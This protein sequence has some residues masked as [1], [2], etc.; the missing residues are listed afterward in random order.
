M[1][2]VSDQAT[3]RATLDGLRNVDFLRSDKWDE[4][5]QRAIRKDARPEIIEFEKAFIKR[6]A[7]L[8]VPMFAHNMVR[9][10][11]EQNALYARGVSKAKGMKGPHTHGCAVDIVHS[12]LGWNIPDKGWKLIGHIGNEVAAA[13]GIDIEWGGSWKKFYDP[14]HWELTN[15]REIAGV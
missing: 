13:S 2:L 4:Q 11:S 12:L 5:Q 3:Y 15:W 8:G 9:T 6:M 14:A 7:S 1:A 10:V